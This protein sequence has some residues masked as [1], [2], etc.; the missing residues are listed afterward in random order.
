MSHT[1]RALHKCSLKLRGGSGRDENAESVDTAQENEGRLH[2]LDMED[3]RCSRYRADS[4]TSNVDTTTN[5][6]ETLPY[7]QPDVD[8][9]LEMRLFHNY[10]HFN[11]D[12]P[13]QT[14]TR[15]KSLPELVHKSPSPNTHPQPEL[16]EPD[17]LILYEIEKQ[18]PKYLPDYCDVP[19]YNTP[20]KITKLARSFSFMDVQDELSHPCGHWDGLGLAVVEGDE[21]G[22]I[23]V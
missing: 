16:Y 12:R 20:C 13:T 2:E 23:G 6:T 8:P 14:L 9:K 7:R 3:K 1:R 18:N 15:A 22:G 5:G 17:D 19:R 4:A 21:I 11:V 10:I